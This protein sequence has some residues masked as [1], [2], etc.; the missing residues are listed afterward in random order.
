MMFLPFPF[1]HGVVGLN[2]L[3]QVALI[4]TAAVSKLFSIISK[5]NIPCCVSRSRH[6]DLYNLAIFGDCVPSSS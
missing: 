2:A 4:T 6:I 1:T 5:R 3:L